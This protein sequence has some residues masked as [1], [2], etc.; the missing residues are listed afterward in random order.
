MGKKRRLIASSEDEDEERLPPPSS[1]TSTKKKRREEEEDRAS[2]RNKKNKKGR[3]NEDEDEEEEE[4][5]VQEDAK[6]VGDIIK[7]SGKGKGKKNHYA[8]FEYDGNHFELVNLSLSIALSF[9]F[10]PFMILVLD[11]GM[12][13]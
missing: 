2:E 13:M 1:S 5:A 11:F 6:P 12:R 9:F 4:E 7:T 3:G 10:S 8:S